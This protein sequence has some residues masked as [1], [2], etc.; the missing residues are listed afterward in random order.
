M[1]TNP[2]AKIGDV[3]QVPFQH[4]CDRQEMRSSKDYF[5]WRNHTLNLLARPINPYK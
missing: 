5:E 3:L 1:T 2:N 4:P